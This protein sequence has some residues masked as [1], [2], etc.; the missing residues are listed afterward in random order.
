MTRR[1]FV[2]GVLGVIG[3]LNHGYDLLLG[4]ESPA[5][6]A[7]LAGVAVPLVAAYLLT[8]ARLD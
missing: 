7:A 6:F 3:A 4:A 8:S 5:E 2:Q 1:R